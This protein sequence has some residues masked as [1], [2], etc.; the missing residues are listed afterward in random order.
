MW[1]EML[2][3]IFMLYIISKGKVFYSPVGN[4]S[5]VSSVLVRGVSGVERA[6]TRLRFPDGNTDRFGI[7]FWSVVVDV[8]YRDLD[9]RIT[10]YSVLYIITRRLYDM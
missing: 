3:N 8:F 2:A 4:F 7:E 9:L 1:L 5:E 10:F 6:G